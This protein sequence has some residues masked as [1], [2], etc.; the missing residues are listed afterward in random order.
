M[1]YH[2]NDNAVSDSNKDNV[3]NDTQHSK[4]TSATNIQ[5]I[6]QENFAKLTSF[7]EAGNFKQTELTIKQLAM[8][9]QTPEHQLRELINQYLGF[10]NFSS[11]LNSYRIPAACLEFENVDNIRKPI[12]TIA[13]ELGYGSIGPFNRAFK[14]ITGKTPTQYRQSAIK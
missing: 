14:D 1:A 13:L 11:F 10:K 4:P 12:L 6:F 9:L 2:L 3:N 5:L 8:T 7:I